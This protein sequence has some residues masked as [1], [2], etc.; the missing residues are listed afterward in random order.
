MMIRTYSELSTLETFKER[1][2]YLRLDG[3][4]GRETFGYDRIFNQR[5]YT[6]PEWRRIRDYVITRDNGCDL[7][8]PDHEINGQ[9]III[10]HLNPFMLEDLLKRPHILL[11]PEYL[12]TTT[13]STHNALHYGDENSIIISPIVRTKNDTCPWRK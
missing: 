9:R 5:F 4:V 6:S 10:H 13:H 7:G 2:D 3:T 8:I 1:F 12:I 11:D